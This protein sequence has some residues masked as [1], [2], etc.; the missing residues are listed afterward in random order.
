MAYDATTLRTIYDSTGGDCHLCHRRVARV[1]YGRRGGRGA[2]EVD[3]SVPR[4]HGGTD[5]ISN[6]K[7]AH[8]ACNRS[9]QAT[10]TRAIRARHGKGRAPLSADARASKREKSGLAAGVLFG[11]IGTLWGPVGVLIGGLV[12]LIVGSNEPAES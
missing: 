11:G 12:G 1:N 9:K 10:A 5:R 2:W 3:H 4:A 8:I 7:P 6:L